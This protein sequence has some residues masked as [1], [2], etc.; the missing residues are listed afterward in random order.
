MIAIVSNKPEKIIHHMLSESNMAQ[1]FNKVIGRDSGY[2]TKP[3]ADGINKLIEIFQIN[4]KSVIF[5]GDSVID[6]EACKNAD[7][8]FAHC[9]YGFDDNVIP[10]DYELNDITSI[11]RYFRFMKILDC[12]LR[13]AGYYSNWQYTDS[14]I[15][16]YCNIVNT[17]DVDMVELGYRNPPDDIYKG[18]SLLLPNNNFKKFSRLL[19]KDIEKFLM[20]DLKV[21]QDIELTV[22]RLKSVS[23]YITGVRIAVDASKISKLNQLISSIKSINLKS[24]Y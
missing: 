9:R 2:A 12:T 18:K 16:D 14:E 8:S 6:S 22:S 23:K 24:L 5:F 10:C 20:L 13:D 21:I 17:L 3:D 7:I 4:R 11:R 15:L 1:Y 19:N